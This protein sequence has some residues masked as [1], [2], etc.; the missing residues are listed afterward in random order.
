MLKNFNYDAGYVENFWN[1]LGRYANCEYSY[2]AKHTGG[3]PIEYKFNSSGYRGPEHLVNPDISVFGS[4]FSFGVGIEYQQCWHQQLG[5]YKVNCY[6]PA[7]I[8]VTNNHIIEHYKKIK[9]S[10][11]TILQFREFKYNTDEIQIPANVLCF[12][13]DEVVPMGV[14]GFGYNSFEDRAE[15]QIHP[16]PKTHQSWAKAL[17]TLFNL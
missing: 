2:F 1:W 11:L 10:G 12:V 15:D 9:P 4:S 14:K 5:N 8:L 13:I 16:G 3:R 7:G 17:K 6:A